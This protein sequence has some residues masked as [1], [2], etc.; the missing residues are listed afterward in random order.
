M[1]CPKCNS[2]LNEGDKFCQVCGSVINNE[3]QQTTEN[4]VAPEA[5][6]EKA[7]EVAVTETVTEA[8]PVETAP[9][10]PEAPAPVEAQPAVQPQP[11]VTPEVPAAPVQPVQQPM[12]LNQ[13]NTMPAQQP[14][15]P[16]QEPK[17]NNTVVIALIGVIV[18]LLIVVV[19]LFATS[20]DDG[21]EEPKPNTPTTEDPADKPADEPV[22][23]YTTTT[24]GGY[25]FKLPEGY[26]AEEY[27][28]EVV[29]YDE[30]MNFEAYATAM[31]GV[32]D[33]L[34]KEGYK[35][36][37]TSS[38][39]LNVTYTTKTVNGKNMLIY[40]ADYQGYKVEYVYVKYTATKITGA[41]VVYEYKYDELKE[42]VY[43]IISNMEVAESSFS[44]NAGT[45]LPKVDETTIIKK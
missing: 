28:G 6:A 4:Q 13:P 34:D 20:G 42:T 33:T 22:A 7:P 1:N 19:V 26:Y 37:L 38:G 17:K 2:P 35:A 9:A 30:N 10:Q 31:D 8:T 27:E 32:F 24:V 40:T 36:Y 11:V 3:P 29:V 41:S 14:M 12:N 44:S 23:K 15:N 18:L 21:K 43:D 45:K 25:K 5:T 39:L 16:L